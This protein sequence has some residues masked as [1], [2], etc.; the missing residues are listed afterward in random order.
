MPPISAARLA[1][2]AFFQVHSHRVAIGLQSFPE[3]VVNE[4][5]SPVTSHRS[6][7]LIFILFLA[8]LGIAFPLKSLG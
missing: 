1:N 6:Y 5:A 4:T 3:M 2:L 8:V 7:L